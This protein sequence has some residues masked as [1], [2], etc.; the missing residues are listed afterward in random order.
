MNSWPAGGL[1]AEVICLQLSVASRPTSD[2]LGHVHLPGMRPIY[3]L[4]PGN[5]SVVLLLLWTMRAIGVMVDSS[6]DSRPFDVPS[7][8]LGH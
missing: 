1:P 5:S 4:R 8:V 7:L 2:R 6:V 3:Q